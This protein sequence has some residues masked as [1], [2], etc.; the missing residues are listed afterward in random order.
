M[1]PD[2]QA[3]LASIEARIAVD[4]DIPALCKEVRDQDARIEEL[5]KDK[6][7]TQEALDR[8]EGALKTI[9][10]GLRGLREVAQ[11]PLCTAERMLRMDDA[12]VQRESE[13]VSK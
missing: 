1:T 10:E 6:A 7:R 9:S 4:T 13:A 11:L 8:A 5:E 3:W 2:K 12:R